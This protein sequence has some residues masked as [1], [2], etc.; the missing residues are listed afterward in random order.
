MCDEPELLRYKL[1]EPSAGGAARR[2]TKLN[3]SAP[4]TE[5]KGTNASFRISRGPISRTH[6]ACTVNSEPEADCAMCEPWQAK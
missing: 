6:K 4:A 1:P 2:R 5:V 3:G